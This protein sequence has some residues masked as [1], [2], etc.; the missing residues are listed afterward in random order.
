MKTVKS[1]M[2]ITVSCSLTVIQTLLTAKQY[3][4]S[5][6]GLSEASANISL[7]K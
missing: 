4:G 6:F 7:Q 2:K 1:V 5:L 3:C